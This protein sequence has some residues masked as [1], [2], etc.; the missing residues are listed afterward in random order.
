MPA[1]QW[2]ELKLDAEGNRF[3]GF[4]DGQFVVEAI[5]DAFVAGGVGL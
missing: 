2:Q 4:L 1:G 3:R 5:D